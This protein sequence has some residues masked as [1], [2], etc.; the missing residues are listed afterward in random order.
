MPL[1]PSAAGSSPP[2][3]HAASPY[4]GPLSFFMNE[5]PSETGLTMDIYRLVGGKTDFKTV[6]ASCAM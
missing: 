4:L 6:A 5:Y 1:P 2:M 3:R